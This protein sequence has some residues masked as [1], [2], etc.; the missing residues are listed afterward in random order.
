MKKQYNLIAPFTLLSIYNRRDMWPEGFDF[1]FEDLVRDVANS[2]HNGVFKNTED[3]YTAPCFDEED[4]EWFEEMG[5][6]EEVVSDKDALVTC[7]TK[8]FSSD[9][10]EPYVYALVY[11]ENNNCHYNLISLNYGTRYFDDGTLINTKKIK[12]SELND[13]AEFCTFRI[14]GKK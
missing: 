14:E 7:G 5:W 13:L 9:E 10:N 11:V 12:L 6:V 8:L 4:F 3:L 2:V 1:V